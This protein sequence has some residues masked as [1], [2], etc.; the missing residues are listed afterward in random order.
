[1]AVKTSELEQLGSHIL[2]ARR[3]L[4][5]SQSDLAE[6][7]ALTQ[8]QISYFESG[9]RQPNLDQLLRIAKALDV[10]VQRFLTGS[11]RPGEGLAEMAVELRRLGIEDLWIEGAIV[12]GAFRRPEEV[13]SIVLSSRE[14]DPRIVEAI[15]AV[16]AWNEINPTLLRAHGAVTRTTARIAWLADIALS[17]E[18]GGGFPGSC[19][20]E[21]LEH[22]L[23]AV[24]AARKRAITPVWDDLGKPKS[25]LPTSPIWKRWHISYD[26]SLEEFEGRARHLDGLRMKKTRSRVLVQRLSIGLQAR[27]KKTGTAKEVER[28]INVPKLGAATQR[29]TSKAR[30]PNEGGGPGKQ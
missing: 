16:L 9:R 30:K 10:P 1:M 6:R 21:P 27:L 25:A 17:I 15:P 11:D 8:V 5:L 13:I 26:A 23:T 3:D 2:Q 29:T 22:F 28:P 14:P 4:G 12:P 18:R 20:K 7:S 24:E 19:R